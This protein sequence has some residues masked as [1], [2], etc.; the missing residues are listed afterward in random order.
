MIIPV[1]APLLKPALQ[2][3]E[4]RL[5]SRHDYTH[6]DVHEH[7]QLQGVHVNSGLYRLEELVHNVND[8]I[9]NR[10]EQNLRVVSKTLLVDLPTDKSYSLDQFVS[11]QE[12]AVTNL[13]AQLQG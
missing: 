12:A 2:D 8:I 13:S 7:R 3:L 11:L 9:E 10:V 6:M 1:T 5:T 4:Y